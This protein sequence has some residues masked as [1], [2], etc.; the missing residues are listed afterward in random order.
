MKSFSYFQSLRQLLGKFKTALWAIAGFSFVINLLLLVAPI[1]MLQ[2]Y[3][4]VLSSGSRETLLVL[5]LIAIFLLTLLAILESVRNRILVL[6]GADLDGNFKEDV[7]HK[8]IGRAAAK[9]P[10]AG[11]QG[12]RDL[13][14]IRHFVS[15]TA[16]LAFFDAP[17]APLFLI[18]VTLMHPL[19]GGV[20]LLGAITIFGLA[21]ATELAS[22]DLLR[23][24]TG[25]ILKSQHFLETCLRNH[26]VLR[27]MNVA[28]GLRLKWAAERDPA[29]KLQVQANARVGFL[30]GSTK[31]VRIGIQI[32]IL[33]CGGW[34]ALDQKITLG[35]IVAASIITGRALAPVEQAIGAWRQVVTVRDAFRRLV[36]LL[37]NDANTSDPMPLPRPKGELAVENLIGV[38]PGQSEP[39]LKGINMA[40]KEGEIF[41]IIGPSGSGKSFLARHIIGS[42]RPGRGRVR[43]GGAD[44]MS[45]GDADRGS[46]VGYLPQ[47]IELFPG[48]VGE[49]IARFSGIDADQVIAAAEMAGCHDMILGLPQNY[50][51][52]IG[53]GGVFLSG[54][55][56]QQIALARAVYK[57]PVLVVLDEPDSNLDTE[58][59]MALLRCLSA[60]K[61]KGLTTLFITHNIH[62]LQSADRIL[63]LKDGSVG[64]IGPKAEILRKVLRSVPATKIRQKA[65]A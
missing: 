34:L 37:G 33:G 54:G 65:Q 52:K 59:E 46:F 18:V 35:A 51:T 31:A 16:L 1:Y 27:A 45:F 7:F 50:Q 2:L 17:W 41:G 5:T 49:N 39:I 25:L 11:G 47:N 4:R 8:L 29:V 9:G 36:D 60:R 15:G 22:R 53:E 43:L 62:L 48:T 32:L 61:S 20:A 55:Q 23:E 30:A 28:E 3:D 12:L 58:G 42:C 64:G 63:V 44:V 19:L 21:V 10:Q 24:S 40:I 6:M 57:E 13:D 56:S 26:D 38:I 14:S